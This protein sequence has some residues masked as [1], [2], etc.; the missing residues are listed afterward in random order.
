M[1]WIGLFTAIVVNYWI[2]VSVLFEL[3]SALRVVASGMLIGT[4]VFFAATC[5]SRLFASQSVTGYPLGLNLIGAM[6]GGL[7]EYTSMLIGM[8]AVWLI[9]LGIYVMAWISTVIF[10]RRDP[11][12]A[13]IP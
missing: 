10:V 5:F 2:D 12:P 13:S 6:G 9:V 11:T 3:D 8:R 4:P 1:S 7:I